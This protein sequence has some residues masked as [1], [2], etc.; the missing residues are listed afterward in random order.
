MR[1]AER[2]AK[3]K[4]KEQFALIFFFLFSILNIFANYL[5]GDFSDL[6]ASVSKVFII[7]SLMAWLAL[8]FRPVKGESFLLVALFFSWLG[9]VFLIFQGTHISFFFAGMLTFLTAQIAY[10]YLFLFGLNPRVNL[11]KSIIFVIPVFAAIAYF[12]KVFY[13][14]ED[15]EPFII[16]VTIYGVIIGLTTVAAFVRGAFGSTHNPQYKLIALGGLLF[17][18]SDTVLAVNKFI[19]PLSKGGAVIMFTYIAAQYFYTKAFK[20]AIKKV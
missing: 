11:F 10:A 17:L 9:D 13:Q 8:N 1:K 4:E 16:P 6:I 15:V 3:N 12:L 14:Q 7:P 2:F 18:I 20:C 19:Q 5:P